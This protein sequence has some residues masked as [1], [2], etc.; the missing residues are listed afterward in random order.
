MRLALLAL[1]CVLAGCSR[2]EYRLPETGATLEGTVTYGS[3]TVQMAQI[4]VMSDKSQAI[5]QIENGR[6]KVE[7]VP[8]GQV[9]IGVN[10]EAMRSNMIGQQMA[11]A[12]GVSTGPALKFISV[13]AKYAEPD[14]SGITTTI[15][16]GKNTFD[17][18]LPAAGK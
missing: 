17:I 7:N 6:Y 12:K 15:K 9:K 8:L 1:T 4:N 18:V 14:T 10:T 16:R 13:P 2:Y 3:E 11:R 5:G